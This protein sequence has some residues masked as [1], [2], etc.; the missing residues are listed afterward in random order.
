MARAKGRGK[1]GT[2]GR[3][4]G[5][6]G[7]GRGRG[8]GTQPA[9]TQPAGMQ[10]AEVQLAGTQLALWPC[11]GCTLENPA[12]AEACSACAAPRPPADPPRNAFSR[13]KLA[14]WTPQEDAAEQVGDGAMIFLFFFFFF[15]HTLGESNF[16]PV[17]NACNRTPI[18]LYA[19]FI[20][21]YIY[22]YICVS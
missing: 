2:R 9:G 8:H 13:L 6:G 3:G 18:L 19:Q 7:R 10:L 14:C 16:L 12:A 22:I 4:R 1:A 21:L 5:R 17:S 15:L 20:I 11:P